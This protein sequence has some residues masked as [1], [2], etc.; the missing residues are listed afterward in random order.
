MGY[1]NTYLDILLCLIA[2][3]VQS[4]DK[5]SY[6]N[7]INVFFKVIMRMRSDFMHAKHLSTFARLFNEHVGKFYMLS[8]GNMMFLEGYIHT[9]PRHRLLLTCNIFNGILHNAYR[10]ITTDITLE[11]FIQ[12]QETEQL[13]IFQ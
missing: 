2:M 5:S 1:T 8:V 13:D 3:A 9:R 6:L 4:S 11:M 7:L 12:L 10:E